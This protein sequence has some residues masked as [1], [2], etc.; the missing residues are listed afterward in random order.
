MGRM[1]INLGNVTGAAQ[2]ITTA[3]GNLMSI[4]AKVYG[5]AEAWTGIAK[6]NGL[7]D[8]TVQGVQTLNIPVTPDN[9][10]GVLTS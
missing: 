9:S 10:G 2:Q 3:G 5:K 7:N 8:P 1:S 4:A 6:A